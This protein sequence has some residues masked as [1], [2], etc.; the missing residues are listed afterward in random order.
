ME[1][2]GVEENHVESGIDILRMCNWSR[3]YSHQC[4]MYIYIY[5][6]RS[7]GDSTP[8]LSLSLVIIREDI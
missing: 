2:R 4:H 7:S 6:S 3:H 5:F 1:I 8:L